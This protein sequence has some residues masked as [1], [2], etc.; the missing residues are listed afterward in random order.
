MPGEVA[1]ESGSAGAG[2][3]D[4]RHR[5]IRERQPVIASRSIRRK[6]RPSPIGAVS[7][8]PRNASTEFTT[9]ALEEKTPAQVA[10][11]IRKWFAHY[12]PFRRY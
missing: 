6:T 9:I 8:Q 3:H 11:I 12:R 2:S 10:E 5:P 7:N 1:R 4:L